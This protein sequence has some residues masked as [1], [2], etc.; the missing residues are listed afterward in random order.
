MNFPNLVLDLK[1]VISALRYSLFSI[2]KPAKSQIFEKIENLTFLLFF[3]ENSI[4]SHFQ[5]KLGLPT[6]EIRNKG[7]FKGL[8]PWPRAPRHPF[9]NHTFFYNQ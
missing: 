3:I 9:T 2:A 5:P 8:A 4:L 1:S 7:H 6:F